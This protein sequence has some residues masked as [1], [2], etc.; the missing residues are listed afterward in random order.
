MSNTSQDSL[1]DSLLP[2]TKPKMIDLVARAGFD[3]SDWSNYKNGQIN[4]GANPRYCYEWCYEQEG[5]FILNIWYENMLFEDGV[6]RQ[7]LNLRKVFSELVGPRKTRAKK[8]DAAVQ[9]AFSIGSNPRAIIQHRDRPRTGNVQYRLL[10]P[11]PWTVESYDDDTGDIGLIRGVHRG[12]VGLD[13][14]A[15]EG[16]IEG[17][18][19]WKLAKHRRREASLRDEKIQRAS[20]GNGGRLLC[21]VKGCGFDFAQKYGELGELYAHVHHLKPLG[22]RSAEGERTRLDDLA[23]VCAN[24]HAM[25]HRR[26]QNLALEEIE[27]AIKANV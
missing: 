8:F 11:S 13:Q 2:Q 17:L 26:G 6:V 1:A 9:R 10:D 19:Y 12:L 16:A 14:D 23:I 5:M 15:E 18:E 3:V 20:N 4:P 25:I 7:Y 21:E 24:C 27:K 22:E